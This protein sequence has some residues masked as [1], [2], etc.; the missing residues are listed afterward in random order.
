MG[1][2]R[3]NSTSKSSSTISDREATPEIVF[4]DRVV[5]QEKVVEVP[6]LKENT[7]EKIVE[8]PVEKVVEKIVEKIVEVEKPVYMTSYINREY[9]NE[10]YEQHMEE[11]RK[12]LAQ[13]QIKAEAHRL[14]NDNINEDL[15][16]LYKE[17]KD[18]KKKEKQAKIALAVLGILTIIALIF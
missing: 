12:G 2:F 14:C 7:V 13:L 6:V 1:K 17:I 16:T 8:V 15:K 5:I 18:L 9:E 10:K 4:Q 3:M 11:A